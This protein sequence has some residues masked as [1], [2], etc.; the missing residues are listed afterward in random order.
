M[1]LEE[2]LAMIKPL[3]ENAMNIAKKRWNSIAK[4]LHSLGKMEELVIQIAGITGSTDMAVQKRALVPMCADNGVV[5]EGVT[6]T[7]QEVTAIVA[8]NFL[9]GDTSACVM[10]RQCGTEVLP[11]D[12]GM[13]VD[14]RVPKDLKVAYGTANMTKGPAMTRAQAVQAL[15]AG[16]EMV[17]R[18]KE[19]GYGLLATGE[20]G[21]GNTTTSSAVASVLL[22]QPVETMTGRGAGLS[23]DGLTRKI[24]AIKKAIEV[25]HPNPGDAIDVL[26]KVGGF[27]IAGMA[28]MFLGGAAFG[29]P[30]VIDGFISC[31][32]ALIAQR[33]C[34]AA[35]EYMI[36]SHV[37]KEPAAQLIL[38]ALGKEAVIHGEMCLGEGSG[39]VALFPFLDM[40]IAVYE[41]MSTFDDIHVEQ[42]EELV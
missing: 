31:V 8:E 7:G 28:G 37:S 18:L 32:A 6:Q 35:G 40:G 23:G 12:I 42:Y 9:S 1:T 4:P 22:N 5:E 16:I 36:A 13:V 17:R 24:N 27:D 26:A 34:P 14:T 19:D 29:V 38:K 2:T 20:M 10:S 11:V 33:I 39:A 21:I 41:S 15:E 30:V 25:N 3:D